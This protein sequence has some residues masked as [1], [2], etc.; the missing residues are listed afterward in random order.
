MTTVV[1]LR[2]VP[3]EPDPEVIARLREWL[4][5]AEAGD[6]RAIA[7]AGTLTGERVAYTFC[8]RGMFPLL[9]AVSMLEHVL[10]QFIHESDS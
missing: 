8:G 3:R 1:A 6:L 9:A 2:P 4:V 5:M 7:M 10:R